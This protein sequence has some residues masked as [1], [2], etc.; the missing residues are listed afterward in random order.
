MSPRP[1]SLPSVAVFGL[2]SL[3]L[4]SGCSNLLT[5][6]TLPSLS[7]KTDEGSVSPT[8]SCVVELHGEFGKPRKMILPVTAETRAQDILAASGAR[9]RK[10]KVMILRPSPQNPAEVV[11]LACDF[12]PGDRKI[13]LHTDYAVLPGDRVV[14]QQDTSTIVDDVVEGLIGPVL[15]GK[16][17]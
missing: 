8:E 15:G 10:M 12:D 3:L 14:V 17:S 1:R 11:K 5:H 16:R 6:G 2:F 4:T 9:Y 13:T 7:A